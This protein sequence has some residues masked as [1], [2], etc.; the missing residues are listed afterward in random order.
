M[1]DVVIAIDPG[2]HQ[3]GCAQYECGKLVALRMV[4]LFELPTL[5][6]EHPSATWVIEDVPANSF[7]YG[8]HAGGNKGVAARKAQNVGMVKQATRSILE[9]LAHHG[10]TPVKIP[11]QGGNWGTIKTN[12]GR[13]ALEQHTGWAGNS[14][15]DTRSAAFFGWLYLQQVKRGW[16]RL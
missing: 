11:P 2:S 16:R 1:T 4:R 3:S 10:V 14:N 5:V 7:M 13:K 12:Y 15:K 8:R 9:L 6:D